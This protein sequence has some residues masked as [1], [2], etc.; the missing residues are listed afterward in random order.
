M[1][2]PKHGKG[3]ARNRDSAQPCRQLEERLAE[4]QARHEGL[5]KACASLS[6]SEAFFR[7]LVENIDHVIFSVDLRGTINYIGPSIRNISGLRPEEV[8]GKH[9]NDFVHPDDQS[10]LLAAFERN[11]AGIPEPH[12][13]RVWKRSG[14]F[15]DVC[16]SGRQLREEGRVVGLTGAMIDITERVRLRGREQLRASALE[17]LIRGNPLQDILDSVVRGIEAELN[18]MD[19]ASRRGCPAAMGSILLMDEERTHLLHGAAPNLPQF[20]N[21]VVHGLEIGPEAGSCGAAAYTGKRVIVEDIQSH[22]NWT[23]YREIAARAGLGSSWSEPIVNRQGKVIG[24]FA[25]YHRERHVP[26]RE[27]IELIQSVAS[28]TGVVIEHKQVEQQILQINAELERRVAERTCEL[29]ESEERMRLF[30]ERQLIG[31]AITSPEKGWVK[32][33]DKLCQMLGYSREEL[34]LRSWAELTYP[35]DLPSSL[36][37]FERI[38]NGEIDS[39]TLEKRFVRKDGGL[40]FANLSI[41]CV[42]RPDHSVDYF[43]VGVEDITQRKRAEREAEEALQKEVILRREIHHRVKN[44]LQVIV[45]LLYL[46]S[47]KTS[48]P[49]SLALLKESQARVGAIAL[50]HE[51]LYQREDLTKISFADYVRQLAADLFIMYRV[52]PQTVA[53]KTGS[54]SVFLPLTTAIPCGIVVT[55]LI[56]NALK[57]AFPEGS[58]GQLEISLLPVQP[59]TGS[60]TLELIVRD[61][62]IGLPKGFD[63]KSPQTMGLSLVR[64]L[65]RQLSGT[66]EFRQMDGGQGTEVRIA[67]PAGDDAP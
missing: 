25:I 45:S 41:G 49:N 32:V 22:S 13:F 12:D 53:L 9:F 61:N 51:M 28:L 43:L 3:S 35:E 31:M 11:L 36:A 46:Q 8:V 40:V 19:S 66:V 62:G 47:I 27:D 10:A 38:M 63:A 65:A 7:T 44:N 48:D 2:N 58:K 59:A 42:R 18:R 15:R 57:Y 24:T 16:A 56:T 30:F 60:K 55:E 5:E 52:S 26:T 23:P 34:A 39:C 37:Q 20:Y 6:K 14:G 17:K 29:V 33:N 67:F 54:E 1:T 64:D 4:L 21:E 50:V